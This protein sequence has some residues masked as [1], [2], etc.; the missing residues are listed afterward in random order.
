MESTKETEG[1]YF[2]LGYYNTSYF[3]IDRE[4]VVKNKD[5]F[6]LCFTSKIS[7]YDALNKFEYYLKNKK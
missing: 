6:D 1:W 4:T 5:Y 7:P 3:S 2:Y